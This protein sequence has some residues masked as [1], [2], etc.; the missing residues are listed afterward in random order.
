REPLEFV[1]CL[2]RPS[3]PRLRRRVR[4]LAGFQHAGVARLM[5]LQQRPHLVGRQD[6]VVVLPAAATSLSPARLR[7]TGGAETLA[8]A[9]TLG[10]RRN[11]PLR[12]RKPGQLER[13]ELGGG[14]PLTHGPSG[15][16]STRRRA[17]PA[18][19]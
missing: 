11:A 3:L 18:A 10:L 9:V 5:Q 4:L 1:R 12:S 14:V 7:Q 17:C 15:A 13:R 19:A 16:P 8:P 2:G 6:A